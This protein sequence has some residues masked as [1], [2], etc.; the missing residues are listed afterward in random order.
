MKW[1]TEILYH[2]DGQGFAAGKFII[3]DL[4]LARLGATV[5]GEPFD[6]RKHAPR[7]DVK[8]IKYHQLL[9]EKAASGARIRVFLDI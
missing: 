9:V 5:A 8:A 1:L 7:L 4:T 2:Y 3:S 6:E